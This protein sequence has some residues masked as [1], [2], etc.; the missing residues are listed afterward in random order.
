MFPAPPC[1]FC[2]HDHHFR[3]NLGPLGPLRGAAAVQPPRLYRRC[4]AARPHLVGAGAPGRRSRLRR[5]RATL[6]RRGRAGHRPVWGPDPGQFSL[7]MS[8]ARPRTCLPPERRLPIACSTSPPCA[9]PSDGARRVPT[10][11]C[12]PSFDEITM[13]V[14]ATRLCARRSSMTAESTC[15]REERAHTSNTKKGAST[16]I[17]YGWHP[18]HVQPR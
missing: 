15:A 1:Q 11:A 16:D 7:P 12:Q 4:G 14:P 9:R 2:T 3:R 6:V 5:C 8:D 18:V 13:K 17:C 10:W